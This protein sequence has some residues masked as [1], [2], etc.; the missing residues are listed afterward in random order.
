LSERDDQEPQGEGEAL[1]PEKVVEE[2]EDGTRKRI[3]TQ[4]RKKPPTR[5]ICSPY[6]RVQ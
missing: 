4:I 3:P 2:K 5:S 6:C 1:D